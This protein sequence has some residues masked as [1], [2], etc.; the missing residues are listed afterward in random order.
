MASGRRSR[1]MK[2]TGSG[3]LIAAF[4]RVGIELLHTYNV[5]SSSY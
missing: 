3:L 5:L 2:G 1:R 4:A